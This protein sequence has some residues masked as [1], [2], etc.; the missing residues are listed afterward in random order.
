MPWRPGARSP[1]KGAEGGGGG[2]LEKGKRKSAAA[3]FSFI[4]LPT[5]IHVSL[6]QKLVV[7]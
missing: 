6:S 2:L 3:L 4:L 1:R 5:R 7:G